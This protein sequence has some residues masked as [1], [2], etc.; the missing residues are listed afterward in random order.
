MKSLLSVLVGSLCL[1]STSV[2]EAADRPNIIYILAD[3]LGYGDLG[4]YG[5]QTLTTPHLDRLAQEGIRFTRHYAGSTVCAPSRCVLMTGRHTGHARIRGNGPGRLHPTDL[6]I[7]SLLQDAGYRTGC[8]GKWGIGNPP[9]L[10]DPNQH[11]FD[12]FYGYVNMFHAH[13]YYPE[14]LIRNGQREPLRN[15]LFPDWQTK[16]TR[17]REGL[18]V[19]EHAVDYAPAL[20][21]DEALKFIEQNAKAPF[22]LYYAV[23]IPHANNE[24]GREERIDRNGMRVPDWGE[25]TDKA[26]PD[27]EKGFAQMIRTIDDHVGA[28]I[29]Q[30]E[31]LGIAD[32]TALFF[33]SDNGPHAEG[34]HKMPFFD[35]NGPLRGMKRDLYEGGIR[36]PFIARWPGHFPADRESHLISGFQDIFPTFAA[37]A[38]IK[39]PPAN[40]GLSLLPTLLGR[41]GD[42]ITHPHLYW[43]FYEQGG[44]VA[45]L[46]GN[47]KAVKRN[48][49]KNPDAGIELYNVDSDPAESKDL[50]KQHPAL[51]ESLAGIMQKEHEEP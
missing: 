13:N 12:E 24:G 2:I 28:L 23:N 35:S 3:D 9:P 45:V 43:E 49:L 47:W 18:G 39:N 34:G 7:A 10:D 21:F 22:F 20:I 8:F 38:G 36:V 31:H 41:A 44:K 16:Q 11:G 32:Q 27:Q 30:L 19:A 17:E 1:L 42:Q 4:C 50:A 33:S 37:L 25:F 48:F 15:R 29:S 46:Q 26:W 40:D 5:Q 51:V 6:T 14:F